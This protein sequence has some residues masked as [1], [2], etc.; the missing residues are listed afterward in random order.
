[1]IQ[2]KANTDRVEGINCRMYERNQ[3]NYKLGASFDPRPTSTKFTKFPSLNPECPPRTHDTQY[4]YV[5]TFNPGHKAP[6]IGYANSVNLETDLY[7]VNHRNSKD[8]KN[9]LPTNYYSDMYLAS[10]HGRDIGKDLSLQEHYHPLLFKKE[11]FDL[12]QQNHENFAQ[13]IWN[14]NVRTERRNHNYD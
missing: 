6:Y 5:S 4:N 7:G 3:P 14:N 2:S 10:A 13:G 11:N 9:Y 1:M 8:C 12:T